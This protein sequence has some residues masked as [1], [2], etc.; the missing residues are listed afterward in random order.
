M[1][2]LQHWCDAQAGECTWATKCIC[3]CDGCT[4]E[5]LVEIVK[6][7][8]EEIRETVSFLVPVQ[9]ATKG[10]D[11]LPDELPIGKGGVQKLV[12]KFCVTCKGL[13]WEYVQ[14][15]PKA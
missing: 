15:A 1:R 5:R 3:S 14:P 13:Y 4:T 2:A 6:R 7:D 8:N 12:V 11:P 10:H 9:C